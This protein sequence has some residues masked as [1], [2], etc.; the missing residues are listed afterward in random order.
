MR[1]RRPI[2]TVRKWTSVLG[3][4]DGRP[5][6]GHQLEHAAEMILDSASSSTV[7]RDQVNGHQPARSG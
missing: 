4:L 5:V 3:N 6:D 2:R 1:V 7:D